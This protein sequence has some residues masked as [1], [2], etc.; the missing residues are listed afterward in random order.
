MKIAFLV[1]SHR[2]PGQLVRLL[3]ALR[4][5]LPDAPIVVHHDVY[6]EELPSSEVEHIRDTHGR[7]EGTGELLE[8]VHQMLLNYWPEAT[9]A[10]SDR[11]ALRNPKIVLRIGGT[12]VQDVCTHDQ[13]VV[14]G[15][16][17]CDLFDSTI[18]G[19]LMREEVSMTRQKEKP[20]GRDMEL[21][22]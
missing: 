5:Q 10:R 20:I 21:V 22:A 18:R 4:S 17:L 19:G 6:R 14:F 9:Q 12:E 16:N 13:E 3:S 1:L 8:Q 11:C 2:P 7:K 15:G